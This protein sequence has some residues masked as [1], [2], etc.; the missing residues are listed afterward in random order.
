MSD[1]SSATPDGETPVNP[2]SLLDAVNRSSDTAHVAWLIFLGIMTYLT[3]AVAGVTHTNLLL[4]TPVS[5]PIFSVD[6]PIAQFFQFAPVILVL[7]H[8]GVVSQL[9]LLARKT[10]EFDHAI[11]LLET[12]DRRT[13]PLRLELHN[14]FF[15][16]AIAGPHRSIVMS[17]FLHGMSWLTLCIL[18]VVLIIYVQVVFLP[19]HS[20]LIT[21][22][23][24][25]ALVVDVTMLVL[26]GVFL[27][28]AETSFFR[29]FWRNTVAHPMT[30]VVTAVVISGVT[31]FSFLVATIPGEFLDRVSR[32]LFYKMAPDRDGR[33][34][35]YYSGF[36]AP[37]L[38]VDQDGALFGVFRRNLVVTDS[39]LV[40]DKDV[41]PGERTI[42]LR[43]RDLRYAR[44]D[45]SDLH[46]ADF[47]GADLS[48]A[49]F[50]G[51]DL[52][53]AWLQCA[54]IN[55]LRLR[56]NRGQAKCVKAINTD[57][58][59]AN[60]SGALMQGID[61]RGAK[62]EETTLVSAELVEAVLTG[63]DF[64]QARL[65]KASMVGEVMADGANFGLASLQGVNLKGARL[66]GADFRSASMQAAI[67]DF[68]NM[69]GAMLQGADLEAASLY[70]VKLEGAD[71]SRANVAAADFNGST[72]WMAKPP[73]A[74]KSQLVDLSD[75]A[76]RPLAEEDQ[77]ALHRAV[78]DIDSRRLREQVQGLV[79]PLMDETATKAWANS[80]ERRQWDSLVRSTAVGSVPQPRPV[81]T[82]SIGVEP[83]LAADN[84]KSQV[85]SHLNSIVCRTRWSNGSVATGVVIRA[86]APQFRGDMV[87]IYDRLNRGDCA[88]SKGVPEDVF[89][90]LTVAADRAMG[91]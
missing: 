33:H 16:Q 1:L 42:T 41:T 88:A 47:T 31:L 76:V 28:R 50:Y 56:G 59:Q 39:D 3:I 12:S 17:A 75:V 20:E 66:I 81:S 72:V 79:A 24:R 34:P 15:V 7:F 89:R 63:A 45:R 40:S 22:T 86:I 35:R 69:Q 82:A 91:R 11:R 77:Q 48:H 21:W 18:P 53:N 57:F 23:H 90:D 83:T 52:R 80:S 38:S 46:Q 32:P 36:M 43:G 61:G 6:I 4:E 54:E 84:Y 25:I 10:L 27:M 78:E 74:N 68:A 5:L 2:Y 70:K 30:F 62:F 65:E 26:I 67:L 64:A 37:F 19:Y 60:M 85:T 8:L 49:S 73:E 58:T 71:F 14:F 51:A 29:A 55:E 9:S 13:H 44:F 87:A